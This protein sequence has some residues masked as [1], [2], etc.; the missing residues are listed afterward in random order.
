[1]PSQTRR[2]LLAS[3]F[4]VEDRGWRW[5]DTSRG[6]PFSKDPSVIR[7]RHQYLLYYSLPQY[8]DG[9][10]GDG[11]A[12]G[13]ARSRNL[14][15]WEKAG[16]ILPQADYE[17]QGL[18][19]PCAVVIEDRVHLFYQ[20]YGNGP[21]DAICHAVSADGIS[22]ARNRT[23]PVFSPALFPQTKAWSSGRAIDAEVFR[24]RGRWH[25]LAATRD[26]AMKTQ[27]VV[28]A[29][30][31]A[32]VRFDRE[33]WSMPGALAAGPVLRPELPWE[34]Q[35]IE[36]PTVVEKA[37]RL[38]MFYAGGYNNE[39]QQVGAA[40]STD[41]LSW[42]RLSS[43]PLLPAGRPGEWNS[44]ES[45]H[46]GVFVDRD[47]TTWLFFQGNNDRGKTWYL[48]SRKLEWRGAQPVL[49]GGF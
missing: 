18:C 27:M 2:Q 24:F 34:R 20:T 44:S 1:M 47:G 46:P 35:C 45:G 13:I 8:G 23:N 4:G 12:I 30:G 6:R 38:I 19:A 25:M 14:T 15:D 10:P 42:Q 29:T 28:G 49:P 43:E 33:V 32:E 3:L 39:P 21:R 7:F 26:P 36:A 17:K 9:R 11:W 22:F 41:G 37:G 16:E 40:S 48:S 31:A 5:A